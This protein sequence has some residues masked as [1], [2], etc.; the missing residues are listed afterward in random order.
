[1]EVE[2]LIMGNFKKKKNKNNNVTE[3]GVST[4]FEGRRTWKQKSR[5][6]QAEP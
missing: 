1:M 2:H 5:E 6:E 3:C 4:A